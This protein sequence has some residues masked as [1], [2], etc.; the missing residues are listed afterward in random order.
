MTIIYLINPSGGFHY[1]EALCC[2]EPGIL[3]SARKKR[4][5][6]GNSN[7]YEGSLSFDIKMANIAKNSL[8]E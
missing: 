5:P 8:V 3:E 4:S 1:P 7:L 2:R 6:D